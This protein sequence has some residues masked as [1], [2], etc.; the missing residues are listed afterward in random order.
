MF[1]GN[2][3]KKKAIVI[4]DELDITP[5]IDVTFLLLIFFMVTSKM[6]KSSLLEIPA[7]RHGLGVTQKTATI[8]TIFNSENTPEVYLADEEKK[9]GPA[10]LAAV[11]AYVQEGIAARK[12]NVIIKADRD[13][14]SGFVDE[15]ARA[16]NE[17]S[18]PGEDLKFY[19]GVID[20][21]RR[22]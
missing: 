16:A 8:I 1:G 19:I 2:L 4:D 10:D 5:M 17:A 12:L 3:K 20:R 18:P 11:T 13:T 9:N 15:V 6:E 14:P 22:E 7:A 21:P